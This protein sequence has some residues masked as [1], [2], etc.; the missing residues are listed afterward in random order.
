MSQGDAAVDLR[1]EPHLLMAD[2]SLDARALDAA[3]ARLGKALKVFEGVTDGEL[4]VKLRWE[5]TVDEAL[6]DI[7]KEMLDN[8]RDPENRLPA[9]LKARGSKMVEAEARIRAKQQHPKLWVEYAELEA[10][11]HALEKWVKSKERAAS[12]RQSILSA[13]KREAELTP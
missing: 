8:A 7:E 1:I 6:L 9:T 4:G 2:L 12:L 3:S 13:Q 5:A 11:I 10:E